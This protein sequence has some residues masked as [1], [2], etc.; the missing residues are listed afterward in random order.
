MANI[1]SKDAIESVRKNA[2]VFQAIIDIADAMEGISSLE[3]AAK[4]AN[5]RLV[6][7]REE[8]A[9]IAG[10]VASLSADIK[11]LTSKKADHLTRIDIMLADA[12]AQSA[13]TIED[14]K[15]YAKALSQKAG[16]KAESIIA[17]ANVRASEIDAA[18]TA[19]KQVLADTLAAI[20]NASKEK[21]TLQKAID[22]LRA[23]FA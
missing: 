20:E 12:N 2:R 23:K 19:A 13:Q 10:S 8:E 11:A 15:T 5:A 4:E 16:A 14:A 9:S 22:N 6:S 1:I 17:D 7:V 18:T 21:G 3:Q